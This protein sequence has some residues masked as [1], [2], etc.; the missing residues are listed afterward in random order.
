MD[1][2]LSMPV[3]GGFFSTD[4]L[5]VLGV[6]IICIILYLIFCVLRENKKNDLKGFNDDDFV[7]DKQEKQQNVLKCFIT[8]K[9]LRKK[10]LVLFS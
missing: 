2:N 4:G 5:I 10:D 1:N 7:E 9:G 3:T 8:K 6:T